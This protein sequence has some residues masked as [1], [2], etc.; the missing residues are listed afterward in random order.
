MLFFLIFLLLI[1]LFLE[2]TITTLPLVLICLLCM[3]IIKRAAVVLPIAFAAGLLLDSLTLHPPGSSSIFF[4]VL[5]LLI[6]LYQRKYEINSYP[7]VIVSSCAGSFL[8]LFFFGYNEIFV[9]GILSSFFCV[10][11]FSIVRLQFKIRN[12]KLQMKFK[13][14]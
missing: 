13:Q 4:L 3:G 6:S 10:V 11:L 5:I 7:F 1:S 2:S 9:Q 12:R 14:V 8:Y